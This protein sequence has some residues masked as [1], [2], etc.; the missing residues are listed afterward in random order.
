MMQQQGLLYRPMQVEDIPALQQLLPGLLPGNWANVSLQA[1]LD[2]THQCRVLEERGEQ[3]PRLFG[4][5]EFQCILDECHLHAI[6]IEAAR[7]GRGLGRQ[8]LQ[9]LLQ[10]AESLNCRVCLL[11]VRRSNTAAIGLYAGQGFELMGMRKGYYPA[12]GSEQTAE[13]ALLYTLSLC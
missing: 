3:G 1:L 4:F 8:F 9:A 5:A 7:Q 11:E 12:A 13:D 2:S 10:E 6:A